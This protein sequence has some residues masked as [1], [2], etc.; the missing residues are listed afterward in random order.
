MFDDGCDAAAVV[1]DNGV[2]LHREK[3][4]CN[5]NEIRDESVNSNVVTNRSTHTR[6]IGFRNYEWEITI[7]AWHAFGWT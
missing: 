7:L 2:L 1:V 4:A 5:S 6:F 3:Q